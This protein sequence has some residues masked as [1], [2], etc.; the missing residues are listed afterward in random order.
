[1]DRF[2]QQMPHI[3]LKSLTNLTMNSLCCVGIW[4]FLKT[5]QENDPKFWKTEELDMGA[6]GSTVI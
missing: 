5:G 3:T 1:M 6:S 2:V 4:A